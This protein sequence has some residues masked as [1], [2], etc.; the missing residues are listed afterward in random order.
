MKQQLSSFG[1]AAKH[2]VSDVRWACF[3]RVHIPHGAADIDTLPLLAWHKDMLQHVDPS[4]ARL[5]KYQQY[6]FFPI[7]CFARMM[8]AQQSFA[9]AALLRKYSSKGTLELCLMAIHY[10]AVLVLPLTV[11]SV[12]QTITFFFLAQVW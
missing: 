2:C 9:H 7:L 4:T 12:W 11:M 10:S 5:L 3:P 1:R 8:W 6:L